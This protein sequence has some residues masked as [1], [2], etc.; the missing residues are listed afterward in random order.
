MSE[1]LFYIFIT[2]CFL[3]ITDV[4][5]DINISNMIHD[6][7]SGEK[8]DEET[9]VDNNAKPIKILRDTDIKIINEIKEINAAQDVF[10]ASCLSVVEIFIF[11]FIKIELS[12]F[13]IDVAPAHPVDHKN[14]N[15]TLIDTL[16]V[17]SFKLGSR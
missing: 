17:K 13:D 8:H 1:W 3:A 9:G 7:E 12:I 16:P 2:S 6:E 10:I 4:I 15:T 5:N 14:T 11:Y